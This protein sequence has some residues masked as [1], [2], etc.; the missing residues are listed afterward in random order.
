MSTPVPITAPGHI[1]Q[2]LSKLLTPFRGKPRFSSWCAVP[3]N[4]VQ[5]IEDQL[6]ALLALL[7]VDTADL[8]RLIL[9]GKIVGQTQRGTLEQFRRY[10]KTRVLVNRSSGTAPQLIKIAGLL[11]GGP[12][13]D[14]PSPVFYTDGSCWITIEQDG[15]S[16]G[17]ADPIAT[18]EFLSAAKM[19]GI[20][21][22]LI[23]GDFD[24]N[25]NAMFGDD[26]IG[27]ELDTNRGLSD[28]A[29]STG[30]F[31]AGIW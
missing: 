31:L 26:T 28:E 16:I 13:P 19:A 30:G 23:A 2:A 10:V 15:P 8:P 21:I 17:D 20:A 7:D 5:E 11:L 1:L 27:G 9:L 6:W 4:Q 24:D 12:T 22:R 29:E 14:P 25:S 3:V 18:V